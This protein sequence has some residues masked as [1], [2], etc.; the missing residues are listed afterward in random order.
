MKK[1]S[2]QATGP[3]IRYDSLVFTNSQRH[4]GAYVSLNP[5]FKYVGNHRINFSYTWG[6]CDAF[7][8]QKSPSEG[9]ERPPGSAK[10]PTTIYQMYT[11]VYTVEHNVKVSK[12]IL[13]SWMCSTTRLF[14]EVCVLECKKISSVNA[15]IILLDN[16]QIYDRFQSMID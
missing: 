8:R 3:M 6:F 10:L 13:I 15:A 5:I 12:K 2:P 11:F 14:E 16:E 1:W 4:R 9:S 7:R